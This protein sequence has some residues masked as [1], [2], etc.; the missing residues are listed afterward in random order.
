MTSE[1][2]T[3]H[4]ILQQLLDEWQG[5]HTFAWFGHMLDYLGL[6]GKRE[7]SE[8]EAL[9][10]EQTKR[11]LQ[12]QEGLVCIDCGKSLLYEKSHEIGQCDDCLRWDI[13]HAG[14]VE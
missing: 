5:H 3:K 6:Q 7:T 12:S 10:R 1:E 2:K 11:L 13:E 9:E 4:Q 8:Y 14:D